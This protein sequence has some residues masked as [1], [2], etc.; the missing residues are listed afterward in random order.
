MNYIY[1]IVVNFQKN[2]YEFFEW[3]KEDKIKNITRLPIYKVSD[4]DIQAL[5]YNRVTIDSDLLNKIKED[6][7]NTSKIFC[8][9]SNGVIAIALLFDNSGN[10]IKRSSLIFEE[11]DEVV[12]RVKTLKVLKIKYLKNNPIKQNDKLRIEKEQKEKIIRYIKSIKDDLTLRYLYYEYFEQETNDLS[13]MKK[14]LINVLSNEWNYKHQ[15]LYNLVNILTK[16]TSKKE[17]L[18]KANIQKF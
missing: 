2:Y 6:N 9:V 11:E 7:K 18:P 15:K 10:L 13:L 16:V 5:K 17:Y 4:S 3:Q 1:D 14:S 8:I 12:S